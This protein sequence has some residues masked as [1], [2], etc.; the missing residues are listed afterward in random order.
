MF[1]DYND[2]NPLDVG[3]RYHNKYKKRIELKKKIC[4]FILISIFIFLTILFFLFKN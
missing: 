3:R 4:I 2:E 1:L